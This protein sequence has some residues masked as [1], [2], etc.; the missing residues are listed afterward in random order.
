MWIRNDCIAT[1]SHFVVLAFDE[2]ETF[3]NKRGNLPVNPKLLPNDLLNRGIIAHLFKIIF[4]K[5]KNAIIDL[6]HN[7]TLRKLGRTQD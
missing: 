6:E 7:F 4:N 1:L 3:G 2:C 5:Q